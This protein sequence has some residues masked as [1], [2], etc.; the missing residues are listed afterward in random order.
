M[1]GLI[2]TITQA[3]NCFLLNDQK[4]SVKKVIV[5]SD[6]MTFPNKIKVDKCVGSCKDVANPFFKVC[7]PDS[8]KNISVKVFDLLSRENVLKNVTFHKSCK[9]NCL[10]D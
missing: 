10:L 6:Y 4:F 5:D 9:C 7:L 3:K 1:L 2:I 8:I